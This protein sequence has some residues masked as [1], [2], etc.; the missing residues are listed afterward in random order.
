VR[1]QH[2]APKL[3]EASRSH[4]AF[5]NT[6]V[7]EMLQKFH[8][9]AKGLTGDYPRRWDMKAIRKF[10]VTFGIL[11]SVFDYVTFC[12][13]LLVFH[14]TQ[15]QFRTAW[16]VESVVSA[17]LIVRDSKPEAVLQ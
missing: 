3:D 11:S 9:T 16:F 5:W 8:T 14:A 1:R 2:D 10:M 6:S 12:L 13:L 15:V 7:A 4:Q 17:S